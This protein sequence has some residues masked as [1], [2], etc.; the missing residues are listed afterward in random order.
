M[1]EDKI[2]ET[3]NGLKDFQLKTVEYVYEQLY[4]KNR[5][6]MLIAD[7]VG[8]GK[9]IVAKGIIAKAFEKF[10]RENNKEVFNVIYICSNLALARQNL[11]KLNFSGNNA[12]IDYSE[13]DDRIT[14][15]AYISAKEEKQ[16]P[17]RIKAFTPATSFDDKTHAG[18]V[19]E[20]ILLYR[21]L[22]QY[23]DIHESRLRWILI[24]NKRITLQTW[25][26]K[27]NEANDF[28]KGK[29]Y[30]ENRTTRKIRSKVKSELRSLLEKEV[31]PGELP[32]TFQAA[33]INYPIKLW[34]LISR[35]CKLR[36]K[37]NKNFYY[38][39]SKEL[40]SRLRFELSR[41]CLEFL[42]SDIFIL[43]EFQRYKQLIEN[44]GDSKEEKEEEVSPAIQL[45]RDIFSFEG[46]KTLMLS[47]TPFKP[48]TNDFDELNNEVHYNEFKTVLKFLMRDKSEG[49][50][51]EYEKDRRAFFS[52]LRH[53]DR[54]SEKMPEAFDLKRNL[55]NLYRTSIV[56]TEKLLASREKDALIKRVHNKPITVQPEDVHDF[57]V[58]DQITQLLNKYHKASLAVPIEYVKSC[59]YPLSFL[60][61]Y[62]HKE[63]IRGLALKDDNLLRLLKKTRHGWLNLEDINLYR[64]LIPVRGK[65]LPN[66]KLVLAP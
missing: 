27:I 40:V 43:D 15:L 8:L 51:K 41:A 65:I 20:R 39:F 34:T 21:I 61:N 50:W 49:F 53:P 30:Q 64:P 24:G 14:S 5:S 31:S 9:T 38:G 66:A 44:S 13:E 59:A 23:T 46:P 37:S 35:L 25:N 7:E 10:Q 32:K 26:R 57:M 22:S 18:K 47:A 42:N 62:K 48:Y 33:E 4:A 2:Q 60:D 12:A 3:I 63:K 6:K 36:L 54:L 28:D 55:E 29:V 19:D 16:F 1:L 17:L 45:A 11:K 52:F 56:R 58:L